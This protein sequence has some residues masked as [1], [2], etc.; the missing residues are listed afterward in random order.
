MRDEQVKHCLGESGNFYHV[1]EVLS[2]GGK[3]FLNATRRWEILF[4]GRQYL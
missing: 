3:N 1:L 2:P 4:F